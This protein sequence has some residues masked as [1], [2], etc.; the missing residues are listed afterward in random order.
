MTAEE[1]VARLRGGGA[2][3]RRASAPP[4]VFLMTRDEKLVEWLVR[5]GARI[6]A[7]YDRN[8][9]GAKYLGEELI[10]EWDVVITLMDVEGDLWEAAA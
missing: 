3:V 10:T 2:E 4:A 7:K 1:L 6:F 8:P 9:G 5:H